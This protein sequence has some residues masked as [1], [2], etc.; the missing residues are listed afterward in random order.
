MVIDCNSKTVNADY[1]S[2]HSQQGTMMV[3]EK[4]APR[5]DQGLSAAGHLNLFF[6]TCFRR[7][8]L[9]SWYQRGTKHVYSLHAFSPRGIQA[10]TP[11]FALTWISCPLIPQAKFLYKAI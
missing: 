9:R 5:M 6:L 7:N 3:G 8:V 4:P 10:A 2:S 11:F 1:S